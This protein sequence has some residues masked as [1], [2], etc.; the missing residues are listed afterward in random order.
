M[1]VCIGSMFECV[2]LCVFCSCMT[3]RRRGVSCLLICICVQEGYTCVFVCVHATVLCVFVCVRVCVCARANK[4]LK[5]EA[6][7]YISA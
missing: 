7:L 2:S 5:M 3:G 1:C 4:L 6:I